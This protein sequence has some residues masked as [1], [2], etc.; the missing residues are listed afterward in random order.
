MFIRFGV[1]PILGVVLLAASAS[2]QEYKSVQEAKSAAGK[3]AQAG[4]IAGT[5]QPLEAALKLLPAEDEKG[6]VE[7]YRALM[8]AYRLL[9]EPA[10]MIEAVEYIQEHSEAKVERALVTN[11][12][13]SFLHQRGKTDESIAR[14]EERLGKSAT[15]ATALAYLSRVYKTVKR[16]KRERGEAL[17][18]QL[19]ALDQERAKTVAEKLEK[20]AGGD[21]ALAASDWKQVAATWI[22]AG[23]FERAKI[24]AN[25]ALAAPPEAR[26]P[27]LVHYWHEGMGRVFADLNDFN[28]AIEHFE[29]AIATAPR[30]E[31][32]VPVQE[33]LTKIREGK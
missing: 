12:F 16:D 18:K 4:N 24:A 14:Y 29:K 22:E 30:D 33:K 23:D 13:V 20:A 10:K 32:K 25:K 9:G 1:A 17:E 6:R 31:L 5:Q 7:I 11:D 27:I 19:A 15:D 3:A 21:P 26:S 28:K 8:R 2:A